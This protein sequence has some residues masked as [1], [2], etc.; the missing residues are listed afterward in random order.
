[1]AWVEAKDAPQLI[2]GQV[3]FEDGAVNLG[4]KKGGTWVGWNDVPFPR[5]V[6]AWHS[7]IDPP[8]YMP[9]EKWT[10]LTESM[11]P[12]GKKVRWKIKS[13]GSGCDPHFYPVGCIRR[14][15]R[16]HCW[17]SMQCSMSDAAGWLPLKEDGP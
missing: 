6:L 17:D 1:M 15:G 12:L 9:P 13:Y 11:P 4:R 7:L 16:V 8:E 2:V 10:P 5:P 3:V 14:D